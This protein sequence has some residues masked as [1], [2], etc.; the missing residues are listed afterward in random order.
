MPLAR[1]HYEKLANRVKSCTLAVSIMHALAAVGF[2]GRTAWLDLQHAW[3]G[4]ARIAG[5]NPTSGEAR[6]HHGV[7]ESKKQRHHTS[8]ARRQLLQKHSRKPPETT[9]SLDCFGDPS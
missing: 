5:D 6:P 4:T 3:A 2:V 9:P 1:L 8:F 7:G